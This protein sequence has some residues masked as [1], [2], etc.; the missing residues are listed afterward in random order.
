MSESHTLTRCKAA[1]RKDAPL[2]IGRV[3][4]EIH[5]HPTYRVPCLWFSL[6]GLP[7]DEPAFNI[8]TVFRHLVPDHFKDALRGSGV[9]GI[10]G[11]VC[12]F[13]RCRAFVN[14][15]SLR[16]QGASRLTSS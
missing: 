5:L 10:S 12:P 8:D 9:G 11:D 1:L 13:S 3:V 15:V 14:L 16:A 4:Y 2:D 6:K 7:P